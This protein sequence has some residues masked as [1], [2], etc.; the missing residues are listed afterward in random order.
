MRRELLRVSRQFVHLI[1]L[2]VP[3]DE[4]QTNFDSFPLRRTLHAND[5][6]VEP[7]TGLAAPRDDLR[8]DQPV[9]QL[10]FASTASERV[11][12][13]STPSTRR[14]PRFSLSESG[15]VSLSRH[16]G[17]GFGPNLGTTLERY[18]RSAGAS[19]TSRK[20][21]ETPN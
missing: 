4:V 5:S 20:P 14:V 1:E 9:S 15:R 7:A 2:L 13:P 12:E 10:I 3:A 11:V 17:P 8:G 6:S 21:R 18:N 19:S 16:R